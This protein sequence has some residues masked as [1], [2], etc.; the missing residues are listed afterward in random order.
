MSR[1]LNLSTPA[2]AA[3]LLTSAFSMRAQAP[4]QPAKQE[5]RPDLSAYVSSDLDQ[6]EQASIRAL[7]EAMPLEKQ[8]E[9]ASMPP[10]SV[11]IAFI[12]GGNGLI[13]YNRLEDVGSYEV[14][15]NPGMPGDEFPYSLDSGLDPGVYGGSGPYRRVYTKPMPA[16]P[17]PVPTEANDL[18]HQHFYQA[19]GDATLACDVGYFAAGDIGYSYMG[20]WSGTWNTLSGS[21]ATGRAVDAGLQYSPAK[22]NYALIMAIAGAGIITAGN[23]SGAA[24]PPRIGCKKDEWAEIHFA[25]FG[26][27]QTPT[28]QP[29]CWKYENH[30][31]DF[32]GFPRQDCN[33]YALELSVGST[34]FVN[35]PGALQIYKIIWFSP[36]VAYGGW[37]GLEPLTVKNYNGVKNVSGY[38]P[39]VSCENC[40]FKWMTSIAQKKENLTDKS[41]YGAAWGG[42]LLQK[43]GMSESS[44]EVPPSELNCTEYPLWE[45]AYPSNHA[46]D[47]RN[48]PAGL[49]G[50]APSVG[51]TDYHSQYETDVISLKY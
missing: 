39:R 51:V 29:S 12:D 33:T 45:S 14:K 40:A 28:A 3:M 42:H 7:M 16:L 44:A 36:D 1:T 27:Y 21:D 35:H 8:K 22:N 15:P 9:I 10:E 13:H 30:R 5:V 50:V 38:L 32:L 25:A 19:I 37:G 34:Q 47:C 48:T 18:V 17:Q 6:A 23:Y 11:H 2:L 43:V 4:E 24:T 26:A 31:W 49:K 20:G 41:W 46:Q